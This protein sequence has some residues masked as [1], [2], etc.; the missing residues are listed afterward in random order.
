MPEPHTKWVISGRLGMGPQHRTVSKAAQVIIMS[1]KDKTTGK[2]TKQC[3]HV[4]HYYKI[5]DQL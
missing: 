1:S 4:Y 2:N 3:L 5:L